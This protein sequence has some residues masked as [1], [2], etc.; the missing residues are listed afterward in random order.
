VGPPSS[1]T[2]DD[3]ANLTHILEFYP[4][5]ILTSRVL[6]PL[7]AGWVNIINN[8]IYR[9]AVVQA[10]ALNGSRA[11]IGQ[12]G[13]AFIRDI[14]VTARVAIYRPNNRSG[15]YTTIVITA[16]V[17]E[18]S[19]YEA[20]PTPGQ[21]PPQPQARPRLTQRPLPTAL[22][23]FAATAARTGLWMSSCSGRTS[24]ALLLRPR[25]VVSSP[26]RK[27]ARP[28]HVSRLVTSDRD[29][30]FQSSNTLGAC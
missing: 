6:S 13:G 20:D 26:K 9:Y 14:V 4:E 11:Y 2:P 28:I 10:Q 7:S 21:A 18:A 17:L 25:P 15:V 19:W 27:P 24:C 30:L 1:T 12:G 29:G 3:A 16:N 8:T 5:C 23:L 22:R